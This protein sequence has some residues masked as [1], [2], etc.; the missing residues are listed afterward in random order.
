INEL[1]I[2]IVAMGTQDLVIAAAPDG[3]LVADRERSPQVKPY[4]DKLGGPIM[5]SEKSW[6][7]YQIIDV[8]DDSM[9]VKVTLLAD[10]RMS[11]HAHKNHKEVWTILA[12][13][14][15]VIIDDASRRV[16]AGDVV[17]I[18]PGVKHT[19]I[20]ETDM[21]LIEVQSGEELTV[22]DKEKFEIG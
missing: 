12:G 2:P 8:D 16:S 20:A 15:R 14:G 1:S 19:I 11:Y 21:K 3:I 7:E 5:Y 10:H 18:E 22:Y 17:C 6:G 4:V 13:K 9:T